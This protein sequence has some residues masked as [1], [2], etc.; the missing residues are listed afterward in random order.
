MSEFSTLNGYIVKDATARAQIALEIEQRE[1]AIQNEATARAEAIQNEAT[2]R[3][4]AISNAFNQASKVLNKKYILI[5]DS[6]GVVTP[7]NQT[8]WTFRFKEKL[9][10]TDENCFINAN[11]G[12]G[13]AYESTGTQKTFLET[14]Q[15]LESTINNKNDITHIIVCGGHN[16]Y[17]VETQTIR[18]KIGE[19][20]GYVKT[21]YPNAKVYIG[22]VGINTN[23]ISLMDARFVYSQCGDQGA[24]YL[25]GTENAM[26]H[27]AYIASDGFHP[28]DIG[29]ASIALAVVNAIET[30]YAT[31]TQYTGV[32]Q[33]SVVDGGSSAGNLL[34]YQYQAGNILKLNSNNGQIVHFG[35]SKTLKVDGTDNLLF[36]CVNEPLISGADPLYMPIHI[37][38]YNGTTFSDVIP[39][40]L[41]YKDKKFY[42]KIVKFNGNTFAQALTASGVWFSEFTGIA[43][44]PFN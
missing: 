6:Y 19:F 27:T 4:E 33:A 44:T 15:D 38:T 24:Y 12:A 11:N 17:S 41:V 10:L 23:G 18:N 20:V 28:N 21:T 29:S 32:K 7:E 14:L 34:F 40:T 1:E 13:F 39:A 30:G 2:A 16:D 9:G 25:N 5:S 8:P 22:Y 43:L 3:A 26:A 42:L 37:S 36:E 35:V 31:V